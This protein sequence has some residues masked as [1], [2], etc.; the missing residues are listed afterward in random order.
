MHIVVG[1][2][3]EEFRLEAMRAEFP[4]ATFTSVVQEPETIKDA[5]GFIGRIPAD[6]YYQASDKLKWVHSPGAGIETIIAI[7]ELVASDIQVSN[8][9]GAHAPFVAEHTMALLLAVNRR[10]NEF[11]LNKSR[12]HFHPWGR[13]LE[14]SSL[15]GKRMLIVGMGNIGRAIAKRAEGFE[16]EVVGVDLFVPPVS[17]DTTVILPLDHLDEEIAKADVV[18]IAVPHTKETENLINADR[19]GSMKKGSVLVGISRGHIIDEAALIERLT[20]GTLYGAGLDVFAQEPLPEDSP[21]W[22]VPNLVITPH[23]APNS[24]LTRDREYEI[25]HDNIRRFIDGSP[26]RNVCDKVAGF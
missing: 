26:L 11:A 16:M 6:V 15:Y 5:D 20:D 4:E 22:D 7:P 13:G 25:I 12:H 8:G 1:R 3:V 23:C 21:L 17:D 10:L 24:P 19:V 2:E 18:V 14:F 9:R